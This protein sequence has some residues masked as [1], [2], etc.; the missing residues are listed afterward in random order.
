MGAADRLDTCLRQ[1]EVADLA[2]DDEIPDGA[3]YIL[4]RHIRVDPVLID[5]VN[6]IGPQPLQRLVGDSPDALGAAI[7]SIGGHTVLE[8]ELSCDHHLVTDRLQRLAHD[9]FV[10]AGPVGFGGV[11]EGDASI[12]GCADEPDRLAAI[13]RGAV[14]LA[15]THAAEADR[16]HFKIVVAKRALLHV[17]LFGSDRF[18]HLKKGFAE[19]T[20]R[21]STLRPPG[22]DASFAGSPIAMRTIWL[23]PRLAIT[24][25]I[26]IG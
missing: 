13:G 2:F 22:V 15:Q 12:M 5:Q 19:I 10:D 25:T 23:S 16:R 26:S 8:A 4:D 9:L 17:V 21:L 3:G 14:A 18:R 7:E 11:E 20:D 1:A 6:H 24:A